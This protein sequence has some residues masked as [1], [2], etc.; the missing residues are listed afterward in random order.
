MK[1]ALIDVLFASD[2]RKKVLL[3]LQEEPKE[4][5]T[6][7]KSLETTRQALLP[8]MKVLEEHYLVNHYEDTYE[9]TTIGKLLVDDMAPLLNTISV[10]D[11]DI[12]YWGT[13]KL[14]F[15]PPALLKRINEL[16]GG[17]V[18]TP[19]FTEMHYLCKELHN[20]TLKSKSL[21]GII[22]I[23]SSDYT[24]ILNQLLENDIDVYAIISKDLFHKLLTDD[25]TTFSH[26]VKTESFH[27]FVYSKEMHFVELIYNDY[28]IFMRLLPTEE[29]FD[30]KFMLVSNPTAVKWA[31]DLFQYYLNYSTPITEI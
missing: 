1:K 25:Y 26:L 3:L 16:E 10:F 7:I 12:D 30:P 17:M 13:H 9:L 28:C 18:M 31:H 6:L 23:F 20:Y 4:T 24:E 14:D 21:Y 29:S 8:Q 15:I 27:F 2:K 19:S 11:S 5:E 22:M